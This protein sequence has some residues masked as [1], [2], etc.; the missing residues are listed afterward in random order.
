MANWKVFLLCVVIAAGL[1]G[2]GLTEDPEDAS[3]AA[4]LDQSLPTVDQVKEMIAE[5][6]YDP[7]RDALQRLRSRQP[8]NHE[9][10]FLLGEV[11]LKQGQ[12]KAAVEHYKAAVASPEVQA[13]SLQGA[14]LC[15]LQLGRT[16]E[17]MVSLEQA[18]VADPSLWRAHNALGRIADMRKEW[19]AAEASYR[20]AIAANPTSAPLHNNL[21]MSY[22][23][24][25]RFDEAQTEFQAALDIDRNLKVAA[26]N[27][28]MTYALRGE[29]VQALAGVPE[30]E[31]PD[32]LNNV[33][34]AAM[35]R[36]DYKAAEAYLARALE[37]SPAYHR[38]AAANLEQLKGI[39]ALTGE[40]PEQS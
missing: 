30:A 31:M 26:T 32:A 18:V 6:R 37:I 17:A 25:Q 14:G 33:G 10:A 40:E 1:A 5:E 21:G 23:M 2:C 13:V 27:I 8:D 34:Y 39:L 12:P 29:Y 20:N 9:V 16:E 38:A 36:G 35:M 24:Q 3:L 7:A 22:V 15:L 4:L 19:P 11:L 28:R